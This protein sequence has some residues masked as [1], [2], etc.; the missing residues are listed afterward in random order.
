MAARAGLCVLWKGKPLEWERFNLINNF[1]TLGWIGAE[2]RRGKNRCSAL[3]MS[4]RR[5]GWGPSTRG[6]RQKQNVWAQHG[7]L[8]ARKSEG[9]G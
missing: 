9:W 3:P 5:R 1:P 6:E 7:A 2:E 4:R 8:G